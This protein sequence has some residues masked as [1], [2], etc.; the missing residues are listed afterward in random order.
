MDQATPI[1]IPTDPDDAAR[2]LRADKICRAIGGVLQKHYPGRRWFADVNLLG[3]VAY[4]A[5]PDISMRYGYSLRISRTWLELEKRVIRAGGEILE[6]F[7]LS[8]NRAQEGDTKYMPRNARGEAL[9]AAEGE[10]RA[11]EKPKFILPNGVLLH[12]GNG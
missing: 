9:G 5:C 11:P 4:I 2:K 3:G 1:Y 10:L 6:R 8:R 12:G 7:H